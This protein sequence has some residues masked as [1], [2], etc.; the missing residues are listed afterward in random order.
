MN[1]DDADRW[2]IRKRKHNGKSSAE[3]SAHLKANNAPDYYQFFTSNPAL[4]I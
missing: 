3:H 2:Q 1:D 4:S